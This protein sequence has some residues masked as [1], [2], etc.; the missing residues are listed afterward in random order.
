M[1]IPY[2]LKQSEILIEIRRRLR[3]PNG[4]RW[5]D[6]EVYSGINDC[7]LSWHGRVSIP[8]VYAL[9]DGWQAGVSEYA[10]PSYIRGS[11][12]PQQRR[13]TTNWLHEA[14]IT[15][16]TD[17]WIDIQ[18]FR[19]EPNGSGG[20]TLRL[21][22]SP[23]SDEGRVIWWHPNGPVPLTIPA[24]NAGI[25]SDDTSLVLSTVVTGIEPAGYIKIDSEWMHYAGVTEGT[26]TTTLSGLLRAVNS[27]TA[28]SHNS[29]TSVYWGVGAHRNDLYGQLYN[30]VQFYLHGLY[31]T[32][33]AES[34]RAHHERMS[35]FNMQRAEEYWRRYTP[36]RKTKMRLGTGGI[37]SVSGND[38]HFY[39]T[40]T[41]GPQL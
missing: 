25:D 29:A 37:G 32:D 19:V 17:T 3:D 2:L 15:S 16:E 26:A 5:T 10:L 11:I 38:N 27:T 22:F 41:W 39:N 8:H 6:T 35:L 12:D 24:L 30:H 21:D 13:F 40:R 7:L 34:E 23:A 9:T 4:S 1:I 31:L 36:A 14:G 18:A 28:A 33:A 20:Q